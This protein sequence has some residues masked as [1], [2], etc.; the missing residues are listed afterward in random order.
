VQA[1]LV[2]RLVPKYGEKRMA[3]FSL[4]G[5]ATGGLLIF[6]APVFWLI[7]PISLVQAAV[8]GFI[9]SSL[10]TLAANCVPEHEQGLLS[11]VNAAVAGLVAALGPLWAGAMYDTVM[12]GAPY[13]MGAVI[14]FAAGLILIRVKVVRPVQAHLSPQPAAG[15]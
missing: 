12:P 13:W 10:G 5:T 2:G 1:G 3:L 6:V 8:T 14:L 9:W 7:F 15:R 11:G 4:I